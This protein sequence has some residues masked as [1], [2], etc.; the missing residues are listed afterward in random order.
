MNG[1]KFLVTLYDTESYG[2]EQNVKEFERGNKKMKRS[3]NGFT[4]IELLVVIAII[5]I[6]A[7]MLMPALSTARDRGRTISCVN[8][9]KQAGL[10]TM[11]YCDDNKEYYPFVDMLDPEYSFKVTMGPYVN[12]SVLFWGCPHSK[13]DPKAPYYSYGYNYKQFATDE[14][15]RVGKTLNC[16]KGQKGPSNTVI[17]QDAVNDRWALGI[18]YF[19]DILCDP[20]IANSRAS[21]AHS[22]GKV[23]NVAWCDG[24]V[25]TEAWKPLF[26]HNG[27]G[28]YDGYNYVTKW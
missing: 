5:A 12:E 13:K 9:L 10:G 26:L 6:L 11:Q 1:G 3:K 19:Y 20:T 8:G 21:K 25:T 18:Y 16:F 7:G 28:N 24:H 22:D 2:R 15:P 27:D 4:L 23:L 17:F 14:T